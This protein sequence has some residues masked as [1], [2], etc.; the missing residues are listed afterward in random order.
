MSM[1]LPTLYT[2]VSG[3]FVVV[4][5]LSLTQRATLEDLRPSDQS[6]P[7]PDHSCAR[8]VFLAKPRLVANRIV[9]MKARL[10]HLKASPPSS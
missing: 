1:K 7:L 10:H 6:M 5:V 9:E 3:H 2:R 8:V 4:V